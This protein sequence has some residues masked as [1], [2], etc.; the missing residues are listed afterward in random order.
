[1]SLPLDGELCV[2]WVPEVQG[3]ISMVL[4]CTQYYLNRLGKHY[5]TL[6]ILPSLWELI[7]L[8]S[9][10]PSPSTAN[11]YKVLTFSFLFYPLHPQSHLVIAKAS[12]DPLVPFP[13]HP[14]HSGTR[15]SLHPSAKYFNSNKTNIILGSV[16][17]LQILPFPFYSHP[18]KMFFLQQHFSFFNSFLKIINYYDFMSQFC[19]T[20]LLTKLFNKCYFIVS[21]KSPQI[22]LL[23]QIY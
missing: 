15:I 4:V 14:D 10:F 22:I 7:W 11:F 23:L 20:P 6:A 2:Q 16:F 18:V 3:A 1:M 17:P 13:N 8:L 9:V 5:L 19:R 12:D 21:F